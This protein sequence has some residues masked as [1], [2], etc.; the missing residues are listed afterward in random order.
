MTF[1]KIVTFL[2]HFFNSLYFVILSA[3]NSLFETWKNKVKIGTAPGTRHLSFSVQY[4]DEVTGARLRRVNAI[5]ISNA[6]PLQMEST[7]YGYVKGYSLPEGNYTLTSEL[8]GYQPDTKPNLL[9]RDKK[10]LKIIIKLKK[11][12]S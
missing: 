7:K 10:L 4:L 1:N 12:I 11:L 6:Q 5:L 3:F 9:I 8:D 2:S